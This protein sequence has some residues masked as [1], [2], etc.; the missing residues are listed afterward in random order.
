MFL[1]EKLKKLLK[2]RSSKGNLRALPLPAAHLIDFSS[3]DYLNFSESEVFRAF[4]QDVLKKYAVQKNGSTGS[5]LL[6]GN[7]I[8]HTA[9]ENKI[10]SFHQAEK[11]LLYNSGYDANVGVLS[12]LPQRGDVILYDEL[13]HASIIDGIRLSFATAYKFKHNNLQHLQE[14]LQKNHEADTL[15]VVSESVF[16][17]DGD[18]ALLKELVAV[19]KKNKAYLIV[20]EAH[21]IGVYGAQGRGLCNSLNV[22]QDCLVRIY[23][24]GKAMG[25]HGA[26]VLGGADLYE[27]LINFSRSF[28]YTTALSPQ[29]VAAVMASY[30]CLQQSQSIQKLQ[31]NILFFNKIT[32]SKKNKIPSTSAIHCFLIAGNEA[33]LQASQKIKEQGLDVRAIKSPTVKEGMERLRICLHANNTQEDMQ[34]LVS[35]I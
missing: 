8:I 3:N 10:A 26:A 11:A 12:S 20:D 14:L 27:Y 23:T 29:S 35:F 32:A 1:P 4:K 18:C 7:S 16:S 2:K 22:E 19:C 5:R 15:Y 13:C 6:T 17:M 21:A 28:I 34:R 24:Y 33:V 30:E 31:E 9:C 25:A